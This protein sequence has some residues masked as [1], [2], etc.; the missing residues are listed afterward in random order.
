MNKGLLIV[1]SGA[2]GVGKGTI[3]KELLKADSNIKLSVSVTTRKPRPGETHGVEY[4][5]I[6]KE[7]FDYMDVKIDKEQERSQLRLLSNII[8]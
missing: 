4:F 2:S 6:S 5:F 3:M 7:E 1:Y 8:F